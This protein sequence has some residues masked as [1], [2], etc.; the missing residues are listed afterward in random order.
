MTEVTFIMLVHHYDDEPQRLGSTGLRETT[1]K[2]RAL[3]GFS[4]LG[5]L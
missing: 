4:S 1:T 2:G 5:D 3:E